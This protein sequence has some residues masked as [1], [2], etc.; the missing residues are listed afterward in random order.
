M[1][2]AKVALI[3][4]LIAIASSATIVF[5]AFRLHARALLYIPQLQ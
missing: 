5:V 1:L 2:A 3:P 4:E